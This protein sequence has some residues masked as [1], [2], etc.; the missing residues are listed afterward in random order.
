MPR[1]NNTAKSEPKVVKLDVLTREDNIRILEEQCV[2]I[3]KFIRDASSKR[4]FEDVKS[5]TANLNELEGEID[6]LKKH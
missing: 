2:Q 5:L 3:K 6:E 4:R 1:L